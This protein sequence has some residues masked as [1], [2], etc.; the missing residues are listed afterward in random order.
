MFFIF[1]QAWITP[2]IA[3]AAMSFGPIHGGGEVH[4]K[5]VE[6]RGEGTSS[7][8]I[9]D[10]I[11]IDK[12]PAKYWP[13]EKAQC[14]LAHQYGHLAGRKHS[15]NPQSLMYPTLRYRQCHRWLVRHGV[16]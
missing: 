16:R 12:A 3:A 2:A 14:T 1:P 8:A 4:V 7:S 11:W 10:T 5:Y 15:S 6:L 13:K 9:P